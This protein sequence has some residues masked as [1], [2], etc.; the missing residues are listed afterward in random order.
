MKQEKRLPLPTPTQQQFT[1]L[2]GAYKYFNRVLFAN[3]LPGCILNFSRLAGTHGFMAPER[4]KRVGEE[5]FGTHEI[6]LTP[7][8]LY[9]T[10]LEIFS[11][12]VHEMVHLW[13]WEFG[14][15]SRNG[16]HN[17]EWAAKMREVGLIPSD[18][19][20]PGGKETGQKMTH[21]IEEGGRYERAF[22][23]MPQQYILPFTSLEG[24]LMKKL[25]AGTGSSG[26]DDGEGNPKLA[27]LRKLRPPSRKKTK[28]C[29]P[30]CQVNVWGRPSLRIRCEECDE[31]YEEIG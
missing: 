12:L 23:K 19:G 17:K 3:K 25:L 10:P 9:R 7:T 20:K 22:K 8:T 27:R 28:Y 4:W 14:E 24:E 1:S 15:P 6:S 11:T 26:T 5:T 21:Y 16:Y 13:Q 30:G 2:N 18:T 31:L 29:C